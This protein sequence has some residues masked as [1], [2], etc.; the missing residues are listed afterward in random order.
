[1]IRRRQNNALTQGHCRMRHTKNTLFILVALLSAC[2]V[3]K[4]RE[5][6]D[7]M[8]VRA[9]AL[10][11]LSAAMEAHVRYGNP[12]ARATEAE[13][14][15]EG[16]KHDPALLTNLGEYRVRIRNDERHAMVLMCS[17]DGTR[18]LLEDA[19][20]T[21]EMDLHHWDKPDLPCEFTLAAASVCAPKQ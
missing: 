21:G 15:A 2:A 12:L 9:S 1:M 8:Y 3:T 17:K 13:L 16:T 20:C 11:K 4:G 19:G 6:A 7:E 14:L 10:T 18:I 5:S